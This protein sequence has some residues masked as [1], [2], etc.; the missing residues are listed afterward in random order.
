MSI[1]QNFPTISPS[2][3]L[4]FT[5]SKKLDSRI[6]F[7]RL[8]RAT[9]INEKGLVEIVSANTPRF[10]H[11]YNPTTRIS[12]SLG[13]LIEEQRTNLVTHN[14]TDFNYS[15]NNQT[16]P[17]TT[18]IA[19]DGNSV[20]CKH[21]LTGA[22]SPFLN[23]RANTTLSA[24]STYTMSMWLKGTTNFSASFAFVG[25]TTSEIYTNTANI[26]TEW[27]RFT[28]TFTL[29]NTQTS[30]R[31]QVFFGSQG[32]DKI[33][34]IWGVQL[35]LGPYVTTYIPRLAGQQATRPQDS[36]IVGG[37]NF[38][39]FYNALESTVLWTGRFNATL[40]T[41]VFGAMYSVDSVPT[42]ARTL[43]AYYNPFNAFGSYVH[44]GTSASQTASTTTLGKFEKMATR[45]QQ[46]NF[47]A[48]INGLP[49][50]TF[51][52]NYYPSQLGVL[53]IG[54][55]GGTVRGSQTIS[56]IVYYPKSLTNS[57]LQILSR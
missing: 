27:Q 21:D 14:A 7:T 11:S 31:L 40:P 53:N 57:Q 45:Y 48:S 37:D 1:S 34:S 46:N 33:I 47:A 30:S 52:G 39:K 13:L 19:P 49:V 41:G 23:C 35:E 10:D 55:N 25:E 51:G 54:N 17:T 9:R 32:V 5:R 20:L 16:I 6:A 29:V 36:V 4:N 43:R 28:L 56:Q 38:R 44:S 15:I 18:D 3:N 26:T 22:T 42:S 50:A 8:S 2:L 12:T 24:G